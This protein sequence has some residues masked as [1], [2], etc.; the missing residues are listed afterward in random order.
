MDED[1][2]AAAQS[3]LELV[4]F[5][6]LLQEMSKR[7][8]SVSTRRTTRESKPNGALFPATE[9]LRLRRCNCTT[10]KAAG[11]SFDQQ[12][13]R[14]LKRETR[15]YI[16]QTKGFSPPACSSHSKRMRSCRMLRFCQ[17]N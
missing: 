7:H 5:A 6:E 11:R 1:K 17:T 3:A 14:N 9:I 2:V 13:S 15:L 8:P 10:R 12:R 4:D 16:A